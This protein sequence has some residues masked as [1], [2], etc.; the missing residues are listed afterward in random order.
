MNVE[1]GSEAVQLIFWEYLFRIFGFESLQW[2]VLYI[3]CSLTYKIASVYKAQFCHVGQPL[4]TVRKVYSE[5]Y[6]FF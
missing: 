1:I 2:A 3:N 5:K 4:Q 6:N